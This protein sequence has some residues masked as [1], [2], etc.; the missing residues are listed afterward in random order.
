[1]NPVPKEFRSA[2]ESA[3]LWRFPTVLASKRHL[4]ER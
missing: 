1:M 4:E 3:R 2:R